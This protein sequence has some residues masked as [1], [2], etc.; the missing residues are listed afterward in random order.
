MKGLFNLERNKVY[1]PITFNNPLKVCFK[2]KKN[3]ITTQTRPTHIVKV[4]FLMEKSGFNG[5][6][7]IIGV[8]I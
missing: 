6:L 1:I 3:T 2:N 5:F 8:Q 7:K 4:L